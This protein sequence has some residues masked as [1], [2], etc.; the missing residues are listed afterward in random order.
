[1]LKA[2]HLRLSAARQ[3]WSALV[4]CRRGSAS[5]RCCLA[6]VAF[7]S[8]L[9]EN[10]KTLNRDRRSC[11]SKTVL[12]AQRAS[13]FNLEIE[14]KNIILRR[15]SIFE[16]LHSQGQ[17][18]KSAAPAAR[19]A[20]PSRTEVVSRARQ[21]CQTR[22][23]TIYS[24]IPL[25]RARTSRPGCS[26]TAHRAPD[27]GGQMRLPCFPHRRQTQLAS[28]TQPHFAAGENTGR[29]CFKKVG[30]AAV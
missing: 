19:S 16:F 4:P 23:S 5:D 2:Q 1:M 7:G 18:R 27:T 17:T 25:G 13:G 10:A 11:S 3:H 29:T 20:L 28:R 26:G 24:I 8:W 15:V 12:V 6:N 22:T 21:Q 9:C 30:I 14:L